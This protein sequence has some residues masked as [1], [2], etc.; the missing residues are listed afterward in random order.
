MPPKGRPPKKKKNIS[1]LRNQRPP[2]S[3]L[4]E[5]ES[6]EALH[7]AL[8]D[9]DQDIGENQ[10]IKDTSS[11]EQEDDDYPD[12][13][14]GF[15][16]LAKQPVTLSFND[17]GEPTARV[18]DADW[19]PPHK[20]QKPKRER[21]KTYAKGPAV[22]SKSNRTKS[23]YTKDFRN[24]TRI[25]GFMARRPSGSSQIPE[26]IYQVPYR[27]LTLQESVELEKETHM[28][29]DGK[30]PDSDTKATTTAPT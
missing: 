1:G 24:Q 4:L 21:P 9:P 3:L 20:Q 22:M 13:A 15:T 28:E 29:T 14:S 6:K 30:F 7:G 10:E 2:S 8:P 17:D 23:R 18:D 5:L 27:S 12:D 19:I 26:G 11:R 16:E 25:D